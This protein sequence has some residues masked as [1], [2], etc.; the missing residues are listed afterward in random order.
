[1]GCVIEFFTY[2]KKGSISTCFV[3]KYSYLF[4]NFSLIEILPIRGQSENTITSVELHM[5]IDIAGRGILCHPP[6]RVYSAGV[7]LIQKL[8]TVNSVCII[9]AYQSSER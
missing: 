9:S 1:M 4:N 6:E 2:I 8:F 5:R 7:H 3:S